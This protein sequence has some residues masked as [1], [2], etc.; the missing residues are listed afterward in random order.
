MSMLRSPSGHVT[1]LPRPCV[2]TGMGLERVCSVLQGSPTNFET[3]L[4]LPLID[5][6]RSMQPQSRPSAADVSPSERHIAHKVIADHA[7]AAVALICDGV[8]PSNT[9]RGYVLRR[10]LRRHVTKLQNPNPKPQTPNSKP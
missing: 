8:L 2:D 6:V 7:R 10:I 9:G 1:P 4:L 5:K 3:D